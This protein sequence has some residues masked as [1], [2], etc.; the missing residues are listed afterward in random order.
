M[1]LRSTATKH[2]TPLAIGMMLLGCGCMALAVQPT[3][4]GQ[5]VQRAIQEGTRMNTPSTGYMLGNYLL[6]EYNSGVSLTP[7]AS[8]VDAVAVA[9]P[10]ERLRYYS[11]LEA[12]QERT[13]T[14]PRARNI[15][16]QYQNK[17]GFVIFA[18]SPYTVDAETELFK[19]AYGSSS[20]NENGKVRQ[21]S[22]LDQ[23]GP[24]TLII[25]GKTYTARPVVDGPYTD[26]F[27]IQGS[28]PESHYLGL[29]NYSFDLSP[30]IK[31]GKISG[32]GI[33]RFKDSTGK[34]EY[35]LDVDLGKYY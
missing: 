18:H 4:S 22:F 11:Y 24:A 20:I 1:I 29:V 34:T 2:I 17:V 28:R 13:M 25:A 14:L 21:R 26:I 5:Q 3:L 33:L 6:K 19:Q 8:E 16:G 35:R 7:G 30:L 32:K 31:D 10:F 23:Y 9:T 15:L 12:L 27:S